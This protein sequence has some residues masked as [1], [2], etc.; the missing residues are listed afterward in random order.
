MKHKN[1][2]F[3]IFHVD[4]T[5]CTREQPDKNLL[6]IENVGCWSVENICRY[7]S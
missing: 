4:Q 7:E 1:S 6:K 2:N 5:Y 3:V